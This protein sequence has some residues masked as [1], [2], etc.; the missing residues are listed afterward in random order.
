[1]LADRLDENYRF[2]T[3]MYQE[4]FGLQFPPFSIAPDPHYL[5]M[6]GQHRE[7][8]AHLLYG[9]QHEGGF[10]LLTG[11]VGTGKT[12]VCRC[13]LE[14]LPE[15]TDLAIVLNPKLT[16]RELLGT[17]CQ[18]FGIAL[19]DDN[20]SFKVLIDRLNRFLLDGYAQGHRAVLI[21]DEAQNLSGG[22]LEQL[23]LLTNLET[24]ERK[25]LQIIL[26]GQP[27]LKEMLA[28]PRLRQLSQRITARYHL[29]PLAKKEVGPYVA[30]RLAVAGASAR[31]IRKLFADK[32]IAKLYGMSQ[33]IPRIINLICD[34]A[35]L[36]AYSQGLDRVD[37][38]TLQQAAKEVLG[39]VPPVGQVQRSGLQWAFAAVTLMVLGFAGFGYLVWQMPQLVP[40][41]FRLPTAQAV[42]EMEEKEPVGPVVQSASDEAITD[43]VLE[44]PVSVDETVVAQDP[45]VAPPP[46]APSMEWPKEVDR[47]ASLD[48]AYRAL[49][50]RWGVVY[51]PKQN[52]NACLYA[53][54]YSLRCLHLSGSLE[55]LLAMNRPAV[56]TLY[57]EEQQ[58]FF[59]TLTTVQDE[60][61]TLVMNGQ[62]HTVPLAE[63]WSRWSGE[64]TLLWFVPPGF[65][66]ALNR[67]DKGTA[68]AWL[69][70]RLSKI[71]GETPRPAVDAV[72]DE[73]LVKKVKKFQFAKD[74]VP[75]GVV[76]P[77]TIIHLNSDSGSQVPKLRRRAGEGS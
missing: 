62:P 21:I 48:Q 37:V 73:V 61:A 31:R 60:T 30:H 6:S 63:L 58:K 72:Y 10:V 41:E 8:L 34:R 64:Y 76:G 4:H 32:V 28:Q 16:A 40:Q 26:I 13:L 70:I 2:G 56:L 74:L 65:Q 75:D 77:Q 3:A 43:H 23:R 9:V 54:D 57:T 71:A 50:E 20:P 7:A 22:V 53:R 44:S 35:L 42:V 39:D 24:N 67:N 33:G 51:D 25:L 68:V 14:Q 19:A 47:E 15:K 29:Q 1:M 59:A 5:Y 45:A 36:G 18:E 46:A 55:S 52:R 17:V 49:Y 11:E 38:K 27:E 66:G 69:E 12:T